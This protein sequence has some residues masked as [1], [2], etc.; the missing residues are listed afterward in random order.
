[1]SV[2]AKLSALFAS[3]LAQSA[4]LLLPAYCVQIEGSA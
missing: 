4:T 2:E 3:T 1:M